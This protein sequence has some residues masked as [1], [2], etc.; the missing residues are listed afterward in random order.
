[1]ISFAFWV[2]F[3]DFPSLVNLFVEF[4]FMLWIHPQFFCGNLLWCIKV[5]KEKTVPWANTLIFSDHNLTFDWGY[6]KRKE[7]TK[8]SF[9][10]TLSI[11]F[12]LN[13]FWLICLLH[14]LTYLLHYAGVSCDRIKRFAWILT[15][16]ALWYRCAHLIQNSQQ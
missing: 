16:S 2:S 11:S 13:L 12:N 15:L 7:K 1:M 4:I 8:G 9:Q 10:S 3:V 14:Q 5:Q 6:G